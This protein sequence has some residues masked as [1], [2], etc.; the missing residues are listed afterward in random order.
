MIA[1]HNLQ[2]YPYSYIRSESLKEKQLPSIEFFYNKLKG[3]ALSPEDYR[4]L[5]HTW[6]LLDFKDLGEFAAT[7]LVSEWM[8]D[9]IG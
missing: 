2:T 3:E 4:K 5:F 8:N 9:M 1:I 6:R 7:Y